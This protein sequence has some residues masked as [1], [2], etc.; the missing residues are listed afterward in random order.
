MSRNVNGIGL[1]SIVI[2]DK[3]YCMRV[4]RNSSAIGMAINSKSQ[5]VNRTYDL[6]CDKEYP[7]LVQEFTEEGFKFKRI[8][9]EDD[10][11][12][13]KALEEEFTQCYP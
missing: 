7:Y 1:G 4:V 5:Y 11:A 12:L 2:W 9:A 8:V 13:I 6:N 3:D 10:G